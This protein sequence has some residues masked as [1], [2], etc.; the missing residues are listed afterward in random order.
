LSTSITRWQSHGLGWQPRRSGLV[1]HP[2]SVNVR[3]IAPE[4]FAPQCYP[5]D[6]PY[7]WTPVVVNYQALGHDTGGGYV[8]REAV[9]VRP[10]AKVIASFNGTPLAGR[11]SQRTS[12]GVLVIA[13]AGNDGV[14]EIAERVRVLNGSDADVAL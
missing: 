13:L 3:A 1:C 14:K 2:A 7:R 5:E 9:P 11:D 4:R 6:H 8:D 10:D 12:A